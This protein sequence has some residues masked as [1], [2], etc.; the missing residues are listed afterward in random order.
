VELALSRGN[1][2]LARK[3]A[4]SLQ[5]EA[6]EL[7]ARRSELE[8]ELLA[9]RASGA[10]AELTSSCQKAETLGFVLLARTSCGGS[11][12]TARSH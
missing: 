2:A 6:S 3:L 10:E 12:P 7:G 9:A 4:A 1:L 8:A 5:Q 11:Q